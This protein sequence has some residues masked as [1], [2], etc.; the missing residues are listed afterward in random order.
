MFDIVISCI[1]ISYALQPWI[2][3]IVRPSIPFRL[4]PSP[5]HS[6][7]Y[8]Y[9][10]IRVP[11]QQIS[12][13]HLSAGIYHPR[14]LYSGEWPNNSASSGDTHCRCNCRPVSPYL[15]PKSLQPFCD[16]VHAVLTQLFIQEVA[17]LIP[18][19]VQLTIYLTEWRGKFRRYAWMKF[20]KQNYLSTEL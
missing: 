8:N 13:L 15:T 1:Y 4:V 12:T 2:A 20:S 6:A 11:L 17:D 5:F 19:H 10:N 7:Y 16:V 3:I 18:C 14:E 9:M